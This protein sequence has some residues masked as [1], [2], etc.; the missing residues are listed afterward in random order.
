MSI[1]DAWAVVLLA[2][3]RVHLTKQ[4][5]K[6]DDLAALCNVLDVKPSEIARRADALL[7]E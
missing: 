5:V 2:A 7:K 1:A 3:L 6:M 4:P